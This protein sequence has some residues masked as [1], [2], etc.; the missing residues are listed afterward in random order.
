V[1]SD[2]V[3]PEEMGGY[4]DVMR[5]EVEHQFGRGIFESW[6]PVPLGKQE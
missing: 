3:S 4:N 5:A 6:E 2:Q 1:S